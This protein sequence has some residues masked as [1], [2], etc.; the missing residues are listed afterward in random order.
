M[1][2][3]A[4]GISPKREL[5]PDPVPASG[6]GLFV[7]NLLLNKIRRTGSCLRTG[8]NSDNCETSP[9]RL[10]GNNLSSLGN[11]APQR[12]TGNQFGGMVINR[13]AVRHGV[14]RFEVWR[15]DGII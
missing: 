12:E 7:T 14:A 9:W 15:F 10:S 13:A 1:T 3:R 11:R 4:G 2:R 5:Y 8:Y 6:E